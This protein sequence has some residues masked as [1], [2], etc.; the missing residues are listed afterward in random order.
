[1]QVQAFFPQILM[2]NFPFLTLS[3]ALTALRV[4]TA[5]VFAAHAVVRVLNGTIPQF[6][7]F[8]QSKGLPMGFLWV[9]AITIFEL[10]GSI[11]LAVGLWR[12]YLAAGFI[13]ILVVGIALIHAPL[14][15][16]VGEHGTGGSEYSFVLIVALV[17]I[18]ADRMPT[19]P[20]AR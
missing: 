14:G 7:E 9:W 13:V 5:L 11:L 19:V 15:W 2:K 10:G 16:F 4:A 3:Q 8:L 17:V 1:V 12:Q 6:G 18:A 20:P